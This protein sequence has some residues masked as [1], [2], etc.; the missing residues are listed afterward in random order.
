MA[1]Y[2]LVAHQTAQS[3]ELFEAA[4]GLAA[5]DP[6]ARFSLLVPATP[7]GDLLTWEEGETKEVARVRARSAASWL[8][9]NGIKVVGVRV[10]DADPVSAIDDELLA[11]RR[12]DTIV[13]ST[14]PPGVSRWIKM[15]VVSRLRRKRPRMPVIHVVAEEAARDAQTPGEAIE[16]QPG[17]DKRSQ[18]QR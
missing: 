4:K 8:Q 1:K 9:A 15:D 16:S 3:R 11:G 13:I 2:L 17:A 18:R 10:G 6:D 12:Y 7:V 14:L 5:Q